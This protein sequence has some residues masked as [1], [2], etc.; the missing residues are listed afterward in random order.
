MTELDIEAG[1]KLTT[2][3]DDSK[4]NSILIPPVSWLSRMS[5][6]IA[7]SDGTALVDFGVPTVGRYWECTSITIVGTDD[8]TVVSGAYV[9]LYIGNPQVPTLSGLLLPATQGGS[10]VGLPATAQFGRKQACCM[11]QDH[12]F[13]RV[14]GA[15]SGQSITGVLLGWD[16]DKDTLQ[17]RP[18]ALA[19]LAGTDQ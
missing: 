2:G 15:P 12:V 8:H 9:A 17:E 16:K 1:I 13:C 19:N 10:A 14:Y 4:L 3:K 11:A 18:Q 5:S 7:A 6:T